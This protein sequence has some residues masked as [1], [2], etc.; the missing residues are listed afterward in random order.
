MAKILSKAE[1][2]Q[3]KAIRAEMRKLDTDGWLSEG[4][5]GYAN[6]FFNNDKDLSFIA[7]YNGH[8]LS[9]EDDSFLTSD[10]MELARLTGQISKICY[11]EP[12]VPDISDRR[13]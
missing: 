3:I 7:D 9:C 2:D 6:I 4:Y 10:I 11:G 1:T 8:I 13:L 5:E 12:E